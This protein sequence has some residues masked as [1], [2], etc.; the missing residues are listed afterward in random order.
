[1]KKQFIL[2]ILLVLVFSTI[3][4]AQTT[5]IAVLPFTGLAQSQANLLADML[6][7]QLKNAGA[8]EIAPR[9]RAITAAFREQKIQREGL[10]DTLTISELGKG[11]NAQYAV[12]AH[13]QQIGSKKLIS[14][15]IIDV[16]S[17]RQISGDYFEYS[18]EKEVVDYMPILARM[19]LYGMNSTSKDLP[20]LAIFPLTSENEAAE[21]DRDIL[22]Q[23]LSIELA[24]AGKYAVVVR[25]SSLSNVMSELKIQREGFTDNATIAE[26]GKAI[27]ADYVLHGQVTKYGEGYI[28]TSVVNVEKATLEVGA[29]ASYKEVEDIVDVIPNLTYQ[30]AKMTKKDFYMSKLNRLVD[31]REGYDGI[32]DIKKLLQTGNLEAKADILRYEH[33]YKGYTALM[34]ASWYDYTEIAKALI[35]VGADVHSRDSKGWTALMIVYWSNTKIVKAL[36]AAGADVNAQD[37][38]GWTVLMQASISGCT[39]SVKILIEAGADVNAKDEGE[40]TALWW[41]CKFEHLETVKILVDAGTVLRFHNDDYYDNGKT[42]LMQ[43]SYGGKLEVVKVLIAAGVD[44]NARDNDGTTALMY[45]SISDIQEVGWE[46]MKE[47]IVIVN[48]LIDA[49]AEVNAKNDYG[50]TALIW[51]SEFGHI[52][53][54]QLL[55][56]KG[57]DIHTKDYNGKTTLML[58]SENGHDEIVR[59]L[60]AA[61]ATE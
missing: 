12:S 55:I 35:V 7:T 20:T 53:I 23:I 59:L 47:F 37:N 1:M 9:T 36:I 45:A 54:V 48:R 43:A 5:T 29:Y 30:L 22:A 49:G 17:F 57:A 39:E 42:A 10:T 13:V 19:L 6:G 11:A 40:N 41:A 50:T 52:D 8:Y 56:A 24:N 58:A 60:K 2:S 21:T 38:N 4:N 34:C 26:I 51:A 44:V 33:T 32:A 25:T 31:V 27:N 3:L 18:T 28:N 14:A 46:L 61:G 15:S 16:E